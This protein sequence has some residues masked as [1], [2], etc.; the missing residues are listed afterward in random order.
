MAKILIVE[1]NVETMEAIRSILETERHV[2]DC[3]SSAEDGWDFIKTYEFDLMIFDWEM[4]G[5]SGVEL[6][7]KFRATG[8]KT[9]VIMLTG[10]SATPDKISGLD[11]GA[12]AYLTKPFE[13]EVLLSMIRAILRRSPAE[14]SDSITFAD[15]KL[16]PASSEVSCKDKSADLSAKEVAALRLLMENA[17]RIITHE[18]LRAAAWPDSADVSSNTVRVFLSSIREKLSSIGSTIQILSIR[19]YG[20]QLKAESIK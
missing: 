16:T 10:R 8:G 14:E 2:P 18:E 15:L 12:D 19:G 17:G 1:D 7:R 5:M 11:S 9:P 20:Y 4:P 6:L 3:T 13:R